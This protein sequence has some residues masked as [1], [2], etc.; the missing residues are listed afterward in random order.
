MWRNQS[1]FFAS[2]PSYPQMHASLG[3][4]L[5]RQNTKTYV[6]NFNIIRRPTCILISSCDRQ[7]DVSRAAFSHVPFIWNYLDHVES[8]I[9]A[10]ANCKSNHPQ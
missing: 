8:G 2:L 3:I 7:T 4:A 5:Y 9:V 10:I 6:A 1:A